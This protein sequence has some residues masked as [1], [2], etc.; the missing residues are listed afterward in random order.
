MIHRNPSSNLRGGL[1]HVHL[2][3]FVGWFHWDSQRNIPIETAERS[4]DKSLD[5]WRS[6]SPKVLG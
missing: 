6:N 4:G 2:R 3:C 5:L 1:H